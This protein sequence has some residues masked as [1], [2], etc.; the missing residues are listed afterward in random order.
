MSVDD[1]VIVKLPSH[2]EWRIA[3]GNRALDRNRV[4]EACGFIPEGEVRN[5]RWDFKDQGEN[6]KGKKISFVPITSS[7][8]VNDLLP[9][10]LVDVH[11]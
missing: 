7:C 10:R 8:D 9:A 5:S 2:M 6:E 1:R 11:V 4:T 3:A